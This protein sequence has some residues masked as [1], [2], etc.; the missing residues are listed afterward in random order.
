M[1]NFLNIS[2]IVFNRTVADVGHDD[3]ASCVVDW[4][5]AG[6]RR[7]ELNRYSD[8]LNCYRLGV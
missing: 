2:L 4:T 6:N 1:Y 3:Y 7:V 5:L 8:A